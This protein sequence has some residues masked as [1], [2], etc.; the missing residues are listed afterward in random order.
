MNDS[1]NNIDS[2]LGEFIKNQGKS[3]AKTKF[4]EGLKNA[5]KIGIKTI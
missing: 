4:L 5:F 1:N 3:D 2:L